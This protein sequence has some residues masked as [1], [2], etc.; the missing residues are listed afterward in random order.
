MLERRED[1]R[2]EQRRQLRKSYR[3]EITVPL[4]WEYEL[5]S[6]IR[7][8]V[9][10]GEMSDSDA[11]IA[12]AY[13]DGMP[14]TAKNLV[15]TRQRA[16]AIAKQAGQ[17]RVYDSIY[18]AHAEAEKCELWTADYRFYRAVKGFLRH[19]RYLGNG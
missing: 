18:A 16:R 9:A 19:V 3:I 8:R 2:I 1:S 11:D 5:D 7:F 17:R 13:I 15:G 14:I 6:I 12:F 10:R 4:L